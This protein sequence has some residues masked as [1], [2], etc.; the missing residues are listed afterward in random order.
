MPVRRQHAATLSLV[1]VAILIVIIVG[2]CA[3]FLMKI[4]GGGR[5]V[6]NATDAG[7]LNVAKQSLSTI[8]LT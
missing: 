3:F 8:K 1:A 7:A 5:E 2:V 4:L 6:A